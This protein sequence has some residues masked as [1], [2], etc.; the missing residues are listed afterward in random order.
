MNTNILL[1]TTSFPG[2]YP[3]TKHLGGGAFLLSEA[4]ALVSQG[5][6]VHVIMPAVRGALHYEKSGGIEID[7]VS[8]PLMSLNP[9]Y[10]GK[11]QHGELNVLEKLSQVFMAMSLMFRVATAITRRSHGLL[12]SNWLQVG[13]L[14]AIGNFGRI[15]HLLSVRGSDVRGTPDCLI[16]IMVKFTPNLLNMYPDDPEIADWVKKYS[17][18]EVQVPGVY[19]EKEILRNQGSE[20]IL[21][22]V[23]RLD[24]EISSL[25]LK[26]LGDELFTMIGQALRAR[27][28]FSV[29]VVGDGKRLDYYREQMSEFS[30][31]VI[32]RGWQATF[33]TE[34][35]RA[36][37][38]I[39]GSG[40]NGVI[41]DTVPYGIPVLISE[42][43]TGSLWQDQRNCFVYDPSDVEAWERVVHKALDNPQL[44]SEFALQAKLDLQK[45]ALPTSHAGEKWADELERFVQL[46]K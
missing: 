24:N 8:Y 39:G 44:L 42:N 7:R 28:D 22:V 14:S 6:E 11:P 46:K 38:V 18:F 25:M 30:D 33:D 15:P 9:G 36:A 16:R 17:F 3:E 4:Q 10:N 35:S 21:T 45:F 1:V 20:K 32:F 37:I 31:R 19:R 13:F 27:D 40:M 26:G 34:L 41:M 43:L 5:Y 29:V 23:G 2:L 12:W